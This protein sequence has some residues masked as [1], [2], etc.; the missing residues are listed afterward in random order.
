MDGME[1]HAPSKAAKTGGGGGESMDT[2]KIAKLAAVGVMLLAAAL[3]LAWNFGI[4][5]GPPAPE[6]L[7]PEQIKQAE[8]EMEEQIERERP[9]IERPDITPAGIG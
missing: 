3:L 7:S 9:I 6:P 1:E 2:A 4:I 8:Q 5:G